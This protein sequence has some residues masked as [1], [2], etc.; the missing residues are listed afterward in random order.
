MKKHFHLLF[1]SLFIVVVTNVYGAAQSNYRYETVPNDPL[2][3]RIYTLNNGLKVYMT[4]NKQKPRIQTFIAVRV[5]AKNDP[6]ETTGLAHY[7][8]HLMFKGTKNFGTQDYTKEE[9]LLDMIQQQFEIYRKTTDET[10]RKAIYKTID[11]LSYEASKISIP[12][13]YDKLMSAIGANGTNAWTSFDETVY[14]EDI[15]SNQIENW[16]KIQS[17]RFNNAVIRGFH[18]ELETVYEEKNM[19]LTRDGRKVNE[20]LLS[21]LFPNHPYGMQTVLGTQEH[22]KNPS[23][24]NI[25][26][27]FKNWYVA[28]NIAICLSGDFNPDEMIATID[29]YFGSLKPNPEIK[30]LVIKPEAPITTPIV[31]E[32][33]GPDAE[34]IALGWRFPGSASKEVEVLN[35]VSQIL[36]NGKAGLIDLNINQKQTLLVGYGYVSDM[37]DHCIYLLGGQPKTGQTLDEV[38]KILLEQINLLKAGKFDEGLLQATINNLKYQRAQQ[39][40][41]NAA[42]AQM[43]VSS[44]INGSSWADEVAVLDRLSKIT[45]KDIVEFANKYFLENNYAVI[46]KKQGKDPNEKKISKPQITPIFT[47]RDAVSPFLQSIQSSTV[48][49]I[50]PVFIDFKKDMKQMTSKSGIPVLYKQNVDNDLFEL[51]YLFDMGNN[52]DKWLGTAFDYMDY[53]GT[54]KLTPEQLKKEF[55]RLACSFRVVSDNE[56]VYVVLSGLKENMPQ[57]ISLFEKLLS[58]AKVNKEAY[59]NMVND[60]IKGRANAKLNQN[61]NFDRL[62]Q[63]G[64]WGA[65]S[66][67]TNLPTSKELKELNPQV[68]VDRIHGL[69]TYKHRILYYGPTA[70]KEFLATINKLHKAPAKLKEAPAGDKFERKISTE[71]VVYVAP[72]EAKQIY[73]SQISNNGDKY[74]SSLRPVISVYNEYFG[75]GMNSIVFQE[76]REARGLAYSARAYYLSPNKMQDPYIFRTMIATQN[77]KMIEAIKAFDDIINNMPQ[78]EAAF[79]LAKQ[80]VLARLRTERIIKSEILWRFIEAKDLGETTDVRKA[81]YEAVQKLTLQDVVAFQKQNVKN[82]KYT[83]CILGDEKNLDMDQLSK[84]GTIK[85]L[86]T[87]EIFGY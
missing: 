82:R 68:L 61:Q 53:L 48:K 56:R 39:L 78:S 54:S 12:N 8:E 25:K 19:S 21:C 23:I 9:P 31:G 18:T 27:Y 5:G 57:A 77:D 80:A 51:L 49:P 73:L 64:I 26:N 32:V 69:C 24:I 13:E 33:V 42:R 85:R 2:K 22:L 87:E 60:L 66:P 44:F 46:Y 75:G 83:Y 79:S 41:S 11:S 4:V 62:T 72:Y 59:T 16:A 52:N 7:F 40:E 15:P 58:D 34:S 74:N 28:N 1:L 86:T 84:Y 47:N 17:D 10:Q 35:L 30:R 29:K 55:Y 76:M 3:A 81:T 6:S 36:Y 71:N 45:K 70:D 38:K 20:K 43:F 14:V 37:S 67:T 63:Y 50:E 65:K